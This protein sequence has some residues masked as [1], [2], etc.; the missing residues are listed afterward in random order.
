VH[1]FGKPLEMTFWIRHDEP[2][3][4]GC[5]HVQIF[6]QYQHPVIHA[7]A[8]N[9]HV[10]FGTVA[11]ETVLTCRFPALR[12]NV[13]K[14]HLGTY[15]SE[16]PGQEVY[17]MLDGL[18]PFEIVRTGEMVLWGWRPNVCAYHEEWSWSVAEG[19]A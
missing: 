11:G 8:F 10:Q 19:A 16:P 4:Q 9:P 15:L 1:Q 17:E 18:C 13:G 14:F 6:N 5:F 2:M 7:Y 3:S 12:L